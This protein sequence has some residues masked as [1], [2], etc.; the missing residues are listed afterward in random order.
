MNQKEKNYFNKKINQFMM[1]MLCEIQPIKNIHM[2]ELVLNL[3][4][5][6]FLILNVLKNL[7]YFVIYLIIFE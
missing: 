2:L 3:F 5:I 1:H 7:I 4:L 6:L